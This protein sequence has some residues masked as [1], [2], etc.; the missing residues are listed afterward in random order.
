MNRKLDK[1]R[2]RL[3][4][5]LAFFVIG[6]AGCGPPQASPQNLPLI[7]SLRTALST[8]NPQWLEQ[9]AKILE[10]RRDAGEG[11]EQEFAMF[12]AIIDKARGGQWQ[13]A[14]AEVIAFQKA[15]RPPRR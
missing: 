1:K 3:F 7:G 6:L 11:S 13:E 12:Q 15:Q 10:A 5:S 8:Q 9:N 4:A 14:E 2:C